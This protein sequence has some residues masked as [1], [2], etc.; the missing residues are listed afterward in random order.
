VVDVTE[1]KDTQDRLEEQLQNKNQMMAAVS[2]EL[3]TPLTAVIGLAELLREGDASLS[4][5]SRAEMID[6]I[7][8]SGFDVSNMVEDLLTAA[9]QEAGQLTVVSVPVNLEAQTKQAIEV[10]G[11][12]V[13]VAV[14]GET[15]TA[16]GDPGRVRQ[17]VR[18]LLTNAVKY[19]GDDIRVD[20]DAQPG[21]A[22]ATVS[23]DGEGVPHGSEEKIFV[24]Y[25]RVHSIESHPN[26]VG[27]GLSISREL[28]R[29][30]GGD[31]V[32]RRD[33][34]RT[35]FELTLPLADDA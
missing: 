27:I 22:R 23:D 34:G 19:G 18:N 16:T 35:R 7:V 26:S 21:L 5:E 13:E 10:I 20:L 14:A 24:S 15:Q 25:Q 28:A 30:M 11:G 32:Y 31:L 3:R 33:N 12:S 1:L 2:H 9:R 8:D 6:A 29:A 4:A 17:I